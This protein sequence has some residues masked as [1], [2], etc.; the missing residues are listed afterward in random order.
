MILYYHKKSGFTMYI[1]S[2]SILLSIHLPHLKLMP[3]ISISESQEVK[4]QFKFVGIRCTNMNFKIT[5]Y[6]D[7]KMARALILNGVNG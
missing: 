7:F 4:K 6:E 1:H 5:T 3:A 2:F